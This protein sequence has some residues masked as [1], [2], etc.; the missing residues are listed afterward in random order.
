MNLPGY[1]QCQ[2]SLAEIFLFRDLNTSE[3][4]HLFTSPKYRNPYSS[5]SVTA[6]SVLIM[7]TFRVQC[8]KSMIQTG[9]LRGIPFFDLF[10]HVFLVLFIVIYNSS[11]QSDLS[12]DP[13]STQPSGQ[14][15]LRSSFML[16]QL[17]PASRF[18]NQG[19]LP[20]PQISPTDSVWISPVRSKKIS[21][22][23]KL[24]LTSNQPVASKDYTL[25]Y[26]EQRTLQEGLSFM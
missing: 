16:L 3:Q 26:F 23:I 14:I 6:C 21:I 25:K 8:P 1:Y 11:F 2:A 24:R 18:H 13:N 7:L 17:F 4:C 22:V 12:I 15:S 9:Q 19:L 10:S 20:C 5:V